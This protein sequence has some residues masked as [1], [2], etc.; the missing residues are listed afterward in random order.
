MNHSQRSNLLRRAL[1]SHQPVWTVHYACAGWKHADAGPLEVSAVCFHEILTRTELTFSV[2]DRKDGAERYVLESFFDFVANRKDAHF[3]H[4]NMNRSE[5]GFVALANR[6]RFVIGSDPPVAVAEGQQHD[7][8]DLIGLAHGRDFAAHPKLHSLG[9][10]N[11]YVFREWLTGPEQ[12]TAFDAGK[13]ADL[14]RSCAGKVRLIAYLADRFLTGKLITNHGGPRVA[15]AGEM[16]DAVRVVTAIGDRALDVS[17]QLMR[18]HA[19]RATLEIKDEYD[20]QDLFHAL[21]R[22][23][24][25]DIRPEDHAS[26]SAGA[27]SRV[28]FVLPTHRLAIELKHARESMTAKT[29]GEELIVDRERYAKHPDV[30]HLVTLVLD[31]D[32][33]IANPRGLEADLSRAA[34]GSG[35]SCSVR[36]YDR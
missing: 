18:R 3:L 27:S 34:P 23:F 1:E 15:F 29:L 6:Y 12:A 7:L 22:V 31:P 32:G 9:L 26:T 28:D 4:W 30:S 10:L 33:V 19:K 20:W 2:T 24:F 5:F 11:G 8:D 21:L 13:H 35:L 16:L 14:K 17:R 25:D 36:I